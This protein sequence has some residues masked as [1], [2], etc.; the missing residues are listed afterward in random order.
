MNKKHSTGWMSR[1]VEILC[2]PVGREAA[3]GR[4]V[5]KYCNVGIGQLDAG[6]L[7]EWISLF[8][9]NGDQAGTET[10]RHNVKV[11]NKYAFSR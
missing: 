3:C 9:R 7:G 11:K 1:G 6:V 10:K 8:W 2:E 5:C 4:D